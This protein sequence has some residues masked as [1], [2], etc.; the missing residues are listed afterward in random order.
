M[1]VIIFFKIKY[2]SFFFLVSAVYLLFKCFHT[3]CLICNYLIIIITHAGA[4]KELNKKN[5]VGKQDKVS[6]KKGTAKKGLCVC[7]AYG[8]PRFD[9]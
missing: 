6:E 2:F 7:A 9:R 1:K 4:L 8:C 5:K 3:L